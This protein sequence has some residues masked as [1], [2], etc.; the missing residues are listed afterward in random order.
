M[1]WQPERYGATFAALIG[2]ERLMELGPGRPNQAA[3]AMLDGLSVERAFE[4]RAI[5]DGD[6]AACCISAVHLYHDRLDKSHTISQGVDTPTGS[7]WHGILHRREPDAGNAGY[8]FRR[9][10]KH[11]VFGGLRQEAARLAAES[12][13]PTRDK[14]AS[15]LV[16]QSA[17][18]PYRFIDLCEK[19]R[20][21]GNDL[22]V[23]CRRIQL[24]EWRLLFDWCWE[25]ATG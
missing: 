3:T 22:E 23:L 21:R 24:A 15:L 17:W 18:D 5:G 25:Q 4:G 9:V 10:G 7:Y 13:A 12:G 19:C 1:D 6:M 2:P 16:D 11:P 14:S 8:W 20:G